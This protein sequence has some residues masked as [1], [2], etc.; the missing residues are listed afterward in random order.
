MSRRGGRLAQAIGGEHGVA[1]AGGG[2]GAVAGAVVAAD[3]VFG[4]G[5]GEPYRRLLAGTTTGALDLRSVDGTTD[6]FR[7]DAGSWVAAATEADLTALDGASGPVL[8]VGCGPGRM[9]RAAAA[10]RLPVL[11]IDITPHAVERTRVDGSYALVRSVFERLPLEGR[12]QTVLLMDGNVGIGGDPEALLRRCAALLAGDGC[13]VVEVDPDPDLDV[14]TLYTV[15]DDEGNE[16]HPF[17]WARIG[18][19]AFARHALAVGL[20]VTG[21][22]SVEGRQFVRASAPGSAG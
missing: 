7:F 5:H 18:L 21:G 11:G 17:P 15:R 4:G 22:W 8:D 13:L 3:A 16:S 9:V 10:R 12:W 19:H 20:V 6:A 14:A 2:T 1:G